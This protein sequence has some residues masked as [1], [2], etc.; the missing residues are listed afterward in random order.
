MDT[1]DGFFSDDAPGEGL[2]PPMLRV[3][4]NP[5]L[6]ADGGIGILGALMHAAGFAFGLLAVAYTIV[7]LLPDGLPITLALVAGLSA[8]RSAVHARVGKA[9]VE[10]GPRAAD[11]LGTYALVA[12]LHTAIC[13][14]L[15][16]VSLPDAPPLFLVLVGSLA[17]MAWPLLLLALARSGELRR[18]IEAARDHE[19]KVVGEDRGLTAL[20]ILMA[21]GGVL[22][23]VMCVAGVASLLISG[24]LSLGFFALLSLV[25]CGLFGVRAWFGLQAGRV[26]MA[27]RDPQRFVAAFDRFHTLAFI[28]V[29]LTAAITTVFLLFV[30]LRGLLGILIAL[31][32]F[33]AGL[34]W[35]R[36]IRHYAQQNLPEVFFRDALPA[37]RRPRD[38]GLTGLGLVLLASSLFS[39]LG[40]LGVAFS[41]LD[42]DFRRLFELAELDA[43]AGYSA[44][45]GALVTFVAGWSLFR[46]VDRF[47]PIAVVYGLVVGGLGIWSVIQ[48]LAGLPDVSDIS[49]P[50]VIIVAVLQAVAALTLPLAVLWQALRHE[51]V[52]EDAADADLAEAFD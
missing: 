26:A 1:L 39:L 18:V 46:M 20:G 51:E 38:A 25:V 2:P 27:T 16:V 47:Q 48:S 12:G 21:V 50:K 36:A 23:L 40:A 15:G 7:T 28:S 3:V 11:G 35:P 6:P 9:L 32:V 14:T 49:D 37:V 31:P 29:G 8:A 5:R 22:L 43:L 24:A 13:V 42:N 33:A 10:Q 44:I 34:A 4:E 17:L 45:G 41:W 52:G 19:H 30:G